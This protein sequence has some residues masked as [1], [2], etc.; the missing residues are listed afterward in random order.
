MN[1]PL[2]PF[3]IGIET[4]NFK[5]LITANILATSLINYLETNE[6]LFEGIDFDTIYFDDCEQDHTIDSLISHD[7]IELERIPASTN[8][9]FIEQTNPCIP[10][11]KV[12]RR[13]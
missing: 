3:D 4:M 6:I 10:T 1:D 11:Y 12:K 7:E 9:E 13:L 2:D 5:Q 8:Y